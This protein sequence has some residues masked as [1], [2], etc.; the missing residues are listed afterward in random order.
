MRLSYNPSGSRFILD[1]DRGEFD[2]R[3]LVYEHGFEFSTTASTKEHAVL[4][5]RD[6]F[7]AAFFAEWGT[8]EAIAELSPVLFEIMESWRGTSGAHIDCPEDQELWPFQKANVE[9]MLRRTNSLVGDEPGLG[10]TPTAICYCNELRARKNLVICPANIRL[11]WHKRIQEWTTLPHPDNRN[12]YTILKSSHGV[13]PN[14]AWTIVSYDLARVPAIGRAL[15][16]EH[17]DVL[18]LD[19]PHLLKESDTKRTQA[20][21]GGGRDR[22]FPPLIGQAEHTIGLTGTPLPNRPREA[23]TLAKALCHDSID[24]ANEEEFKFRYNPSVKKE[25]I[26]YLGE[27]KV[28]ID[29]RSG[30]HAELQNRLRYWFMCRHLKR[31][32]RGVMPQLKLPLYDLIRV[33]E[34]KAVKQALNAE[35]LLDLDVDNLE[36]ADMSVMGHIAIAR[37]EMGLA[38]APQVADHIDM[39]IEDGEEKLVVFAW[40]LDVLNILE[41]RFHTYGCL[42]IDGSTS[43]KARDQ[44]VTRFQVDPGIRVIIGNIQSMGVGVDGLQKVCNHGLIAE[45]DWVAGNNIQAFDRLDRG[46]QNWQVQGD[47]F[48]APGSISEKILASAVRKNRVTHASLDKQLGD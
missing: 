5:T 8:D 38:I 19:E 32:P 47:I 29:E 46:G 34:T 42:R 6:R 16:K 10:K 11:Q 9:Y 41:K 14:A 21:F 4:F 31:G 30:R 37:H 33:E 7:A 17:Y 26:N 18:I 12:I 28:V 20:I 48:V 43:P 45:P 15:A 44:I 22:A 36:G 40:H 1:F 35:R 24:F 23:F 39:L 3:S 25:I 13:N 2:I 27:K